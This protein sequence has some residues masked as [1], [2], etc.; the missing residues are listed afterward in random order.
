MV[1]LNRYEE[2]G[3]FGN[4]GYTDTWIFDLP[5]KKFYSN[6]LIGT[7]TCE[8]AFAH[9]AVVEGGYFACNPSFTIKSYHRH[10]SGVRNTPWMGYGPVLLVY[11]QEL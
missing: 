6:F 3:F 4:E 11:A 7:Q 2:N 1:V 8:V 10:H 9:R 5:I